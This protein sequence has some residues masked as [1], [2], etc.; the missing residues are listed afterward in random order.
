MPKTHYEILG[1]KKTATQDQIRSAYRQLVLRY[2]PD[3]SS[4]P[5]ATEIFIRVNE[6]YECL[7]DPARRR[8]YDALQELEVKPSEPQQVRT[9][10][11]GG[12]VSPGYT[13]PPPTSQPSRN[14]T[15][16][17]DVTRLTMLFTRGQFSE[18]ERLARRIINM[19]S[20]QPIPYAVLG[21]LARTRG[22]VR[23]AAKMYSLAIQMDPKNQLYQQR[24]EELLRAEEQI[25]AAVRTST[26]DMN[27]T[28]LF[29]PLVGV[30]M[31]L[32]A[33][34]YLALSREQP[35]FGDIRFVSTWTFGLIVM[36]FLSGVSVGASMSIA[37]LLDRLHTL[38]T[39]SLGRPA[40]TMAL[41]F[42]AAVSFWAAVVLYVILGLS[43]KA[44]NFSTSRALAVTGAA[45]IFLALAAAMSG[46]IDG[47]EVAVWGGNLVYLGALSGWTVADSFRR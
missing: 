39:N 22:E 1:V 42:V 20:R 9:A 35:I 12:G 32:L 13:T 10:Q 14:P 21:D 23:E 27:G 30:A 19:D 47:I 36:L 25:V 11:Y 26:G 4:D 46:F 41:G 43:Q 34:V 44:F 3:R 8:S 31:V 38:T 17:V 24:Y 45:T 7:S 16:T 28:Q 6:A 2:H 37:G 40:P 18:A 33:C 29:A 5:R 15:V